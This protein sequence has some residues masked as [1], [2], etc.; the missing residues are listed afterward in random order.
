M[1]DIK[2]HAPSIGLAQWAGFQAMFAHPP[3]HV[4][5][6]FLLGD[7]DQTFFDPRL[8]DLVPQGLVVAGIESRLRREFT[9]HTLDFH[10]QM[11]MQAVARHVFHEDHF[12][13]E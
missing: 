12:T 13:H 7:V 5:P 11:Q 2:D 3:L 8:L 6:D 10:I 4:R 9:G 1:P